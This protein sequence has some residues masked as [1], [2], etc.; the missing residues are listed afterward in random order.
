VTPPSRQQRPVGQQRP[1]GPERALVVLSLDRPGDASGLEAPRAALAARAHRL[2]GDAAALAGLE[3]ER[4][5]LRCEADHEVL[6]VGLD[7]HRAL[8]TGEGT[9]VDRHRRIG[10]TQIAAAEPLAL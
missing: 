7:P 8:A 6:I 2:D 3:G 5:G 1:H 4:A 10:P 9:V